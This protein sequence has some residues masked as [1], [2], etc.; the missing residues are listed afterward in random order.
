M[1]NF[2]AEMSGFLEVFSFRGLISRFELFVAEGVDNIPG[3]LFRSLILLAVPLGKLDQAIEVLISR[4]Q[5]RGPYHGL[6]LLLR[7][8][9]KVLGVEIKGWIG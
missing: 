1:L 5:L 2:L 9:L 6:K 4:L 7:H 3:Q 8:V